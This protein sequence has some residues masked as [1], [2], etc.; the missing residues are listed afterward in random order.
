M[1]LSAEVPRPQN[2]KE[3]FS[4]G[5]VFSVFTIFS[6]QGPMCVDVVPQQSTVSRVLH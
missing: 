3:G 5:S 2:L 4:A 6:S 1:W